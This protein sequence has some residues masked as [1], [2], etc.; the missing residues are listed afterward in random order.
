MAAILAVS[1]FLAL[2]GMDLRTRYRRSVLG[3]RLVVAPADLHDHHLLHRVL[4]ALQRDESA[5]L[6]SFIAGLAFWNSL[7]AVSVHSSSASWRGVHP[8]VSDAAGHII[9]C[10]P[11]FG[12]KPLFLALGV[13][14][15]TS[16]LFNGLGNLLVLPTLI[17]TLFLLLVIG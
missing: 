3:D 13:V 7:M 1:S 11:R 17:P 10:V 4:Q 15:G 16:W 9:R 14:I 2:V 6:H 8:A 12:G 5:H